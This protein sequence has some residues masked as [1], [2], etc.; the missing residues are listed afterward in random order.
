ML[1]NSFKADIRNDFLINKYL[2]LVS[3]GVKQSEILVLVQNSNSKKQFIDD[4]IQKLSV[5]SI[6][7]FNV[8]SF[9]SLVY[10]TLND[11]WCFIE[12]MI[13][14]DKHF[15]LPN[16]VGLE[17][18]NFILK[19]ILKQIDV[20]GYNSKKSLLHQIL[21]RYSLIVQNNLTS[22][23]VKK[24]SKILKEPFAEDAEMILKKLCL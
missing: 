22:D 19:D 20:K 2:N 13:N 10:T 3:E 4:I 17:V 23:E 1:L 9:Y 8:H 7:R 15:I 6:E 18:S 11:N 5:T 14:S 12:N 24:R 16:L 21:R